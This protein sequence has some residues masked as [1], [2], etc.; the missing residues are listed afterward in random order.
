MSESESELDF[1][2][3]DSI[4]GVI[5]ERLDYSVDPKLAIFRPKGKE[6]GKLLE[7][8]G[9]W[10]YLKALIQDNKDQ[11]YP[12]YA[13]G[14]IKETTKSEGWLIYGAM[15][16]YMPKPK[17][18]HRRLLLCI[19]MPGWENDKLVKRLTEALVQTFIEEHGRD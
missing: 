15:A 16:I 4:P 3:L 1:D 12:Y 11:E 6:L 2:N 9:W 10:H 5:K 18:I 14:V 19:P 17:L 7:L 13:G 8:T